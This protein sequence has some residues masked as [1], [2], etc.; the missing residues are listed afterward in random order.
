MAA[1]GQPLVSLGLAT[2]NS[3]AHLIPALDSILALEWT[4]WR[5][6]ISDDG[7]TD[8]TADICRD[9]AAREPR[10]TFHQQPEN[11]GAVDNLGHVARVA[12]GKYFMWTGPDDLWEPDLLTRLVPLLEADPDLVIAC[13]GIERID[14]DGQ[15]LFTYNTDHPDTGRLADPV[16]RIRTA[17]RHSQPNVTETLIRTSALHQTAI[18]R[19]GVVPE[20]SFLLVELSVLG[21]IRGVP[22]ILF[23]KRSGGQNASQ[24]DA[25]FRQ[26]RRLEAARRAIGELD[27]TPEQAR[28]VFREWKRA[29]LKTRL[30]G[31]RSMQLLKKTIE[32][33]GFKVR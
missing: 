29:R 6:Y 31:Y 33:A 11:M 26:G 5:L 25:H 12:E 7:S 13:C 23:H 30:A 19:Q 32:A 8:S 4:N 14:G 15:R 18:Y 16:D 28:A 1:T 3:A 21:G 24:A 2:Y 27:L 17:L 20:D 10:I 9:Y 22:D